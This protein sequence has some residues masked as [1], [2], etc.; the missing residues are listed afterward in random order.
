MNILEPKRE[1]ILQNQNVSDKTKRIHKGR[2][3]KILFSPDTDDSENKYNFGEFWAGRVVGAVGAA[4][5]IYIFGSIFGNS[6]GHI[7]FGSHYGVP[8]AW[9]LGQRFFPI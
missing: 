7:F 8:L 9:A 6:G 4:F 5:F 2:I 3:L 1:E